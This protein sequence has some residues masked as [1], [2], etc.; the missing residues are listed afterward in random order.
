ML[1]RNHAAKNPDKPAYIMARSGE[2]VTWR[3]FD[4]RLNRCASSYFR[5]N[6]LRYE[7]ALRTYSNGEAHLFL[8]GLSGRY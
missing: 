5:Y 6:Y 1:P 4:Q 8:A 2:V 7:D 3:D